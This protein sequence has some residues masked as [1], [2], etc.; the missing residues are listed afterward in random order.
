L[1]LPAAVMTESHD[2]CRQP[3]TYVKPDAAITVLSSWW[4]AVCRSKHG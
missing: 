1:W 4:W 3:Q 2:S